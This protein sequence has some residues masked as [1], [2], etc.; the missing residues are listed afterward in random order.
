MDLTK[1]WLCCV[2]IVLSA[3]SGG[4]GNGAVSTNVAPSISALDFSPAVV[5]FMSGDGAATIEV[6]LLVVDPESDVMAVHLEISNGSSL[7]V[8]VQMTANV[9]SETLSVLFDLAT[10]IS[11]V[12]TAEVWV[13]DR[14]NKG[15]NHLSSALTVQG[16]SELSSLSLSSGPF[17]QIFDPDMTLYSSGVGF[18]TSSVDV[19]IERQDANASVI[20]NSQLLDSIATHVQVSLD[21]GD[22][23]ISVD[24]TALNS[25][26]TRSY[27]I[28]VARD[29]LQAL[30]QRA[31]IKGSSSGE[32]IA[33]DCLS[34]PIAT[35]WQSVPATPVARRESM[36]MSWT[37]A[38]PMLVL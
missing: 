27:L 24:V 31:Y 20:V 10:D 18:L 16:S 5:A 37:L 25:E 33:S 34:Q 29:P 30:A 22:N 15:S 19:F 38:R 21:E 6:Q 8:P 35:R 23:F 3:C 1:I 17:E 13:V 28:E 14:T 4:G 32:N 2:A 7:T 36:V 11:G 26:S 9:T 12:F